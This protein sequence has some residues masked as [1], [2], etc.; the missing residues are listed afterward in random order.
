MRGID[1]QEFLRL[2]RG[3]HD[4][5]TLCAKCKG[6]GVRSYSSTATWRGGVGGQAFTADVCDGCWGSGVADRPWL[7]LRT[8]RD[9]VKRQVAERAVD[10]LLRA[11]G[12]TL[13]SAQP[14]VRA[15]IALLREAAD[16]AGRARKPQPGHD[17]IWFAPLA[18]TLADALE[19]GLPPQPAKE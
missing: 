4:Y 5:E 15:I 13:T 3:I 14:Q 2:W 16:K 17:S 11:C 12:A 1:D 18:R 8:L 6:A 7:N 9:D 10:V 19:R